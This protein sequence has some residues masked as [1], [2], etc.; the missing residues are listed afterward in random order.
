MILLVALLVSTSEP[1][2]VQDIWPGEAA[3]GKGF[4]GDPVRSDLRTLRWPLLPLVR[5]LSP[6][7]TSQPRA[8]CPLCRSL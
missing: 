6:V 3:N 5:G 8:A 7:C 4:S 1:W 2:L